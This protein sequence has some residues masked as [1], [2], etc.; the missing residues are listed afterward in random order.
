MINEQ[1]TN[2]QVAQLVGGGECFI[3]IHPKEPL[4]FT[5]SL[6]LMAAEPITHV[7]G[8][9]TY[10]PTKFEEMLAVDTSVNSVT[11][12]LPT[13]FNGREFYVIKMT[14]QNRVLVVPTPTDHILGSTLGVEIFNQFT[15]LHFK[16]IAGVPGLANGYICK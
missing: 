9:S 10:T 6:A 12:T 4:D 14:P 11:I 16:A 7:T 5:D 15:A 2:E 8:V 13:A 3:H 1:L